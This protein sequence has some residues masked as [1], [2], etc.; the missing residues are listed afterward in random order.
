[1]ASGSQT[2]RG[3]WADFPIAPANRS[4]AIAVAADFVSVLPAVPK[5]TE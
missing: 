4:S 5:M 2:C 1:M 3:T